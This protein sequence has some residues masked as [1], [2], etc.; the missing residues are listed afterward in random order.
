MLSEHMKKQIIYNT[1]E[2]TVMGALNVKNIPKLLIPV[3]SF[4]I[5]MKLEALLK[6]IRKSIEYNNLQNQRLSKLRDTLLPKLM[7]GEIDV[8]KVKISAEIN[9]KF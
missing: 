2:G 4:E 7:N 3:Y 1:D 8:S 9:C 5:I 6:P